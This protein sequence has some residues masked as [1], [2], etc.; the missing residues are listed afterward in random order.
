MK[1]VIFGASGDLAKRKLFPALSRINTEGAEIIGY[2]RSRFDRPFTE[3]LSDLYSYDQDF[4]NRITYIQGEYDDLTE[5]KKILTPDTCFYM[6]VPPTVYRTILQ[7]INSMEYISVAIEK[8]FGTDHEDLKLISELNVDKLLFI[9]HFLLK[10]LSVAWPI[11]VSK[12]TKLRNILDSSHVSSVEI[13][14]KEQIGGEGRL[15]FDEHGLVKDVVQNHLSELMVISAQEPRGYSCNL[16][17]DERIHVLRCT[18]LKEEFTIF[19]QY[20][21][22]QSE[23]KMPSQTETYSV[24]TLEINDKRWKDVPFITIAGKGLDEKRTEIIYNIRR[25]AFQAVLDITGRPSDKII[26]NEDI[27]YI[28]LVC[29]IAPT[30]NVYLE[31][32]LEGSHTIAYELYDSGTILSMMAEKYGEFE[33]HEIVFDCLLRNK[34]FDCVHYCEAELLWKIYDQILQREKKIFKYQKGSDIPKEALEI[35]DGIKSHYN[36]N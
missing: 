26:N 14:F 24:V 17:A 20:D 6:S 21:S 10:P 11:I 9:D 34:N 7:E 35:L 3:I 1:I 15:Y 31:V 28:R 30:N 25:S 19:G 13:L 2:A 18:E 22:Y 12:E 4:L 33:N 23:M 36:K 29:N 32:G 8:P 27:K 16:Q 5:L